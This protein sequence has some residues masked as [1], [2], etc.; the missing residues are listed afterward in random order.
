MY[1]YNYNQLAILLAKYIFVN[2][3]NSCFVKTDCY[4]WLLT[5]STNV[6]CMFSSVAKCRGSW[7]VGR[8]R[9]CGSG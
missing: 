3:Q 8:G 1:N 9:G 7:V 4:A 6:H 5:I 2:L